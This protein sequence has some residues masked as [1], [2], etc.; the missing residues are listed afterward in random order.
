MILKR[1][2]QKATLIQS[3]GIGF[4]LVW[5]SGVGSL[6]SCLA[7]GCGDGLFTAQQTWLNNFSR[8]SDAPAQ[9]DSQVA[10]SHSCCEVESSS[11]AVAPNSLEIHPEREISGSGFHAC[12]CL[13]KLEKG[14]VSL[15]IQPESP[16]VQTLDRTEP[17]V[18]PAF[19][20]PSAL[21]FPQPRSSLPLLAG[22]PPHLLHCVF[23]I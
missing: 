11:P 18:I 13:H 9:A 17:G 2:N 14:T 22:R 8:Q 15:R 19:T 7:M 6:V 3:V 21:R 10:E 5:L 4:F 16:T 1:S 20:A 23:L 12:R